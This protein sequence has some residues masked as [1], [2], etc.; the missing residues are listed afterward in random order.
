M[1]MHSEWQFF[2]LQVNCSF[3]YN[4]MGI[5]RGIMI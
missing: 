2:V 1:D 3:C 5:T 4:M